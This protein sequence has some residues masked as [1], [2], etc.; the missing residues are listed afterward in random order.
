MS[1]SKDYFE[2]FVNNHKFIFVASL[3]SILGLAFSL[4]TFPPAQKRPFYSV[5][6]FDLINN[7]SSTIENLDIKY[8]VCNDNL[9]KEDCELEEIKS[10]TV[11]KILFW[12]GGRTKIDKTDIDDNPITIAVL[13]NHQ[14]LEAKLL[15]SSNDETKFELKETIPTQKVNNNKPESQKIY[16]INFAFLE[17]GGGGVI[18]VIHTGLSD[19]DITLSGH[20]EDSKL[21]ENIKLV[22][23]NGQKVE[24]IDI[25]LFLIATT[26]F[27]LYLCLLYMDYKRNG[28][29]SALPFLILYLLLYLLWFVFVGFPRLYQSTWK[30]PADSYEVF[31]S[32]ITPE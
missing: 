26:I 1:Q 7:S 23:I 15:H 10:L 5:R 2:N 17:S 18:Q 3:A 8:K 6:S 13:N 4:V 30:Y 14:I 25:I 12:N 24:L 32:E 31:N 28:S 16:T 22:E 20:V 19:K 9:Q 29:F 21:K 27:L 11:T